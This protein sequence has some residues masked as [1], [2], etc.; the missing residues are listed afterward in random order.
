MDFI[1]LFDININFWRSYIENNNET[2]LK[3][4]MG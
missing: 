1:E 4:L 2:N 3:K